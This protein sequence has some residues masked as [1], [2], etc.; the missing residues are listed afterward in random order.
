MAVRRAAGTA[1]PFDHVIHALL[2]GV[3]AK[4][5]SGFSAGRC[6]RRRAL[7]GHLQALRVMIGAYTRSSPLSKGRQ[8]RWHQ[9]SRLSFPGC[10][11]DLARLWMGIASY[12]YPAL[13]RAATAH[14]A[15][16]PGL[17]C[18]RRIACNLAH[19]RSNLALTTG[20]SHTW[21]SRNFVQ[22]SAAALDDWNSGADRA[23]VAVPAAGRHRA[24]FFRHPAVGLGAGLDSSIR[25]AAGAVVSQR[26]EL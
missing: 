8:G 9:K 24:G 21:R 15:M 10:S 20:S 16:L 23:R 7:T 2:P 12:G 4:F 11:V 13:A 3:V 1:L 5:L 18:R 19:R 22:H 6:W 14:V 17:T 25:R 26:P